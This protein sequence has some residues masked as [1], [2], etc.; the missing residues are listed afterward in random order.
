M[1]NFQPSRLTTKAP[2]SL[3]LLQEALKKKLFR[4]YRP[5]MSNPNPR[6]LNRR[7]E[8][9]LLGDASVTEGQETALVA[10]TNLLSNSSWVCPRARK[11]PRRER[12]AS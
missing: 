8:T 1:D 2:T 4:P 6:F 3:T 11:S 7:T 9:L 12:R 5:K 10:T